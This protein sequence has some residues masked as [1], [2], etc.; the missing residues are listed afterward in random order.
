MPNYACNKHLHRFAV[1][2]LTKALS[3]ISGSYFKDFFRKGRKSLKK[4]KL[5]H[6]YAN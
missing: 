5:M 1:Q 6:N 3:E 4:H 2:Y